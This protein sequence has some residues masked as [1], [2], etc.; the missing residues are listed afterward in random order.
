MSSIA[1]QNI[2]LQMVGIQS[3]FYL[4]SIGGNQQS[5]VN[6]LR[7][8]SIASPSSKLLIYGFQILRLIVKRL[9]SQTAVYTP[10]RAICDIIAQIDLCIVLRTYIP[11]ILRVI[12]AIEV[13]PIQERYSVE[14]D[15]IGYIEV[16]LIC[17]RSP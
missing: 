10:L 6:R 1:Y 12:C 2:Y 15:I 3:V 11:V 5:L 16:L 17:K 14:W 4:G 13:Y 9:H 8:E 7:A